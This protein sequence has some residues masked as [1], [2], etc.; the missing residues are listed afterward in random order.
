LYR[1]IFKYFSIIL[2]T[3]LLV[4]DSRNSTFK[5]GSDFKLGDEVL[6]NEKIGL[7][8]D[9]RVAVITNK[10][11]ILSNGKFLF[12]ALVNKG[13]NVVKIFTP[14]HGFGTD[15]SYLNLGI[16]IPVI[17]LYGKSKSIE[18]SDLDNVDV[19]IFDIQELGVRYYTYTSTLYLTMKDA[20]RN[21]KK[22]ILCDR[23]SIANL[24]YY[25]GFM[26]SPNFTSFVGMIP[27]P[28]M[29]G[30]TIGELGGYLKSIINNEGFDF[31]VIKMKN[32]NRNT[33]Y[34][35]LNL[36]W[37]NPSPNITSF[38]SARTYPSLCFMEGT[39]ISE[40]RGTDTPFQLFGAPFCN[41]EELTFVLN[42]F[43]LEGVSFKATKFTPYKKIS[44]YD[45]KF[46]NEECNGVSI[47]VT[48]SKK[49]RPV[50][51]A[52]AVLY[53]LRASTKNFKWIENN[54]IDKL[55][56]TS[57][58]RTM[59]DESKTFKEIIDSYSDEL[60]NFKLQREKFLLYN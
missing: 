18:D 2:F 26:L 46:M 51:V 57:K 52:I 15:D 40:G 20:G 31:E 32:Y 12:E 25:D 54:Y 44:S 13:V 42:S 11:G 59:I 53:A 38:E 50:E 41:G 39:N 23:P 36:L 6:L 49:Y 16:N 58:L 34:D 47:T 33:K 55:A 56:G 8:K 9:K 27:T 1:K 14:E 28:I 30:M 29:F 37:E 24:N 21:G 4:S 10:T 3:L 7:L 35:D 43:H 45:P 19:L 60:E 5:E 22:F 48:D 17:S